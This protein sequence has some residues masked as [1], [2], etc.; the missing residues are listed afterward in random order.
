[1]GGLNV[2]VCIGSGPSLI[3]A[4]V[5]F[6]RSQGW[7]L[8][9]CNLSYQMVP[10]C[11]LFHAMDSGWWERY[12]DDAMSQMDDGREVWTGCPKAAE[13]WGINLLK[14]DGIGGYSDKRGICHTGK[15]SGLQL[16]NIVGWKK[17]DYVLL[18]GYDGIG[19]HW[20]DD[21]PQEMRNFQGVDAQDADYDKLS[22]T[23]PF[24]VW[25]ISRETAIT[26]FPSVPLE[27]V[28]DAIEARE[29]LKCRQKPT[30]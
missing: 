25:N 4:D 8:A 7:N 21:Y 19:T 24:P 18:L 9:T 12:G 11:H 2:W 13:Q 17:P 29:T 5:R 27:C 20:H 10:D 22:A 1:M 16:I 23:V 15:L 26:A 14:W 30:K 28:T 6:C 3:Q